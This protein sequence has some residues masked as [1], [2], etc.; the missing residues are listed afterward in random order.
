VHLWHVHALVLPSS[1]LWR[2]SREGPGRCQIQY[3][4]AD[5][6]SPRRTTASPPPARPHDAKACPFQPLSARAKRAKLEPGCLWSTG[7][8][9]AGFRS[10]GPRR[11][12]RGRHGAREP[13]RR[14][15]RGARA[16]L[17]LVPTPHFR[18]P[19]S[20]TS[21][22]SP[23]PPPTPCPASAALDCFSV[24]DN[25]PAHRLASVPTGCALA[26]SALSHVLTLGRVAPVTQGLRA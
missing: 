5:P 12:G 21:S 26:I 22:S 4:E 24:P 19:R 7:Q 2:A 9:R 20:R 13:D 6:T 25:P 11:S 17:K 14:F 15:G 8:A 10:T 3:S 23:L 18:T 1:D 16:R